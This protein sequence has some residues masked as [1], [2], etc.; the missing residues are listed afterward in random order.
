MRL[1]YVFQEGVLFYAMSLITIP[2]PKS[3]II[4]FS[5]SMFLFTIS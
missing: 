3:Y 4:P 2:L 1:C 5:P